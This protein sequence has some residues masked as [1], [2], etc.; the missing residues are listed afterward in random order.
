MLWHG[1]RV[2][3]PNFIYEGEVGFDSRFS[4]AGYYGV[5]IYFAKNASYSNNGYCYKLPSGE[6]QL[7]LAEVL[8]GEYPYLPDPEDEVKRAPNRKLTKPPMNPANN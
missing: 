1:T 4:E 6:R 3:P 7:F 5:A 2:T 8:L